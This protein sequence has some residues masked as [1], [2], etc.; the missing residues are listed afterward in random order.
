MLRPSAIIVSNRTQPLDR[1]GNLDE[2]VRLVDPLVQLPSTTAMVPSVSWAR[3]GDTSIDTKPSP[4]SLVSYTFRRTP[5]A[6]RTSAIT[7]SQYASSTVAP[8]ASAVAKSSS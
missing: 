1:G 8:V 7:R 4:P 6:P 3:R 5:R 2:Q